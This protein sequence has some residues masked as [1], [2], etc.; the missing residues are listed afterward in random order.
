[1][2]GSLSEAT[3]EIRMVASGGN[4]SVHQEWPTDAF[5][6]RAQLVYRLHVEQERVSMMDESDA[7]S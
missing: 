3:N 5:L 1:M 4:K 6:Q 7:D 2:G